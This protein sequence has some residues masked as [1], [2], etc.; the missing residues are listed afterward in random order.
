MRQKAEKPLPLYH[1]FPDHQMSRELEKISEILDTNPR[2][3]ELVLQDLCDNSQPEKGASG[4]SAE[5]V[6]RAAIVKQLHGFSYEQLAFHLIDSQ[7]FRSF[8]RHPLG[9]IP[10]KSTLQRNLSRISEAT[11]KQINAVLVGW[12]AE[13]KLEK[14]ERIRIDSTAVESNIHHPTDSRLLYDAVRTVSRLLRQLKERQARV[15]SGGQTCGKL[16]FTDHTRRAKRRAY[17]IANG[18]GAKRQQAYRDLLKVAR[19]TYGY[20][21]KALRAN[22][23]VADLK[24]MALLLSLE[25]Y[26]KLMAKVIEQTERRILGGESVPADEKIVSIFEEHTDIIKKGGREVV[27]GH[28]IFLT[29]GRSSLILDCEVLPGNPADAGRLKPLLQTHHKLYGRYPRQIAADRGFYSRSNLEWARQREGLQDAAFDRKGSVKVSDMARSSWIY[30]QLKRFRAG[31][32]GCVSWLKRIF[33]LDRCTWKGWNHFCQYVQASVVS[34]NLLI[35]ARLL[36]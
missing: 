3:S 16:V 31:I 2:I 23:A 28:K 35:L 33:G 26:L 32:E 13:K 14:G 20:G 15:D 30:R 12:A 19:K 4:L 9:W 18:R 24:T 7:S 11:W 34:Y 22:L 5:F 29:C 6:L 8:V 21:M 27:F 25:H 17:Q 10:N 36:L 1:T